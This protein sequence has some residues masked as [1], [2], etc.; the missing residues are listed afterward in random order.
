MVCNCMYF[1]C[2]IV[3][4]TACSD[5]I[6]FVTIPVEGRSSTC[7]LYYN[8]IQTATATPANGTREE[9][10]HNIAMKYIEC[11]SA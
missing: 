1:K 7:I 5:S 3:R 9:L 4:I 6:G 8:S 2:A 11:Y 10:G